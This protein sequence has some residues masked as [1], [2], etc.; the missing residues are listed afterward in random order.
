MSVSS[1]THPT[2][3][4]WARLFSTPP[5]WL[6]LLLPLAALWPVWAWSAARLTDG[7]DDPL[8]ILA[9]LALLLAVWRDRAQLAQHPRPHW[10]AVSLGLSALAALSLGLPPLLRGVIGVAAVLAALLALRA[11]RQPLLAWFGLGLLALPLISS[12]Q[13]FAGYPL[14]VLTAEL[15]ALILRMGGL[16]VLREGSALQV[17][18]HLVMVDAPC[19]GIQMAWVAYFTACATA[20]WLRL[21][22]SQ[23]LRRLPLLGAIVIGGNVLRNT[24]L[25]IK[26]SGLLPL[27]AWTHEGIGLLVFAGVCAL[28]LRLIARGAKPAATPQVPAVATATSWRGLLPVALF[29]FAFLAVLPLLKPARADA[30]PTTTHIEWP[31]SFD[32]HALRPLALSAVEE[33]FSAGFPGAIARFSDGKRLI[34]LRHVTAATRKLHPAADCYRGLG[35]AISHITLSARSD[36][37]RPQALQRCFTASKGGRDLLVCEYTEDAAGRSY[38]DASA[39]YWAATTGDSTGPWRAVTVARMQ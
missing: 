10:F 20:A 6:W 22:D 15:S 11:P 23:F 8:G 7:S 18:G 32:G 35:Y 25:I 24:V 14:R 4:S 37:A 38:T 3:A 12:L 34:T 27:P 39:W 13:F 9:L 31:Q 19:S 36:S 17:A 2:Q 5:G 21:P 1:A 16:Q 28:V 33:R 29:G 26:E 30:V